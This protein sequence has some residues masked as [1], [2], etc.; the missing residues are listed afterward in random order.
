MF[1]KYIKGLNWNLDHDSFADM[2]KFSHSNSFFQ[3]KFQYRN[4]LHLNDFTNIMMNN[5]S[6]YHP[7]SAPFNPNANLNFI[8]D[9]NENSLKTNILP[10]KSNDIP[11]SINDKMHNNMIDLLLPSSY[12]FN[13][14]IPKSY[15][16]DFGPVPSKINT[17]NTFAS[18][19]FYLPFLVFTLMNFQIILQINLGTFI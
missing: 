3:N 12:A 17:P 13:K 10:D 9:L 6:D 4:Q 19:P 14:F 5:G 2:N 15:H 7:E 16:T 18:I 11:K 8:G 1:Y